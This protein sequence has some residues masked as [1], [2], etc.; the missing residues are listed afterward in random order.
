[1][2]G[3]SKS[4]GGSTSKTITKETNTKHSNVVGSSFNTAN[5]QQD[6]SKIYNGKVVGGNVRNVGTVYNGPGS[7]FYHGVNPAML[8]PQTAVPQ[9]MGLMNLATDIDHYHA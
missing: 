1:M 5:I 4:S 8:A 3:G 2:G 9:P 7:E 6:L